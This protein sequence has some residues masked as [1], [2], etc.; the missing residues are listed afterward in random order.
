MNQ[1]LEEAQQDLQQERKT[2]A[3]Y[4]KQFQRMVPDWMHDL[5]ENDSVA[6]AQMLSLENNK[7]W[8]VDEAVDSEEESDLI[9]A[10][11][12]SLQTDSC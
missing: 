4:K 11:Q 12:K 10:I 7:P 5:S 8:W 2:K 1:E 3:L 9:E 6:Y